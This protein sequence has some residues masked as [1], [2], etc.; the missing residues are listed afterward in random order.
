M[1]PNHILEKHDFDEYVEG[2]SERFY[3]EDDPPGLSPGRYFRLLL[4][5]ILQAW[6]PSVRWR[7]AYR[8]QDTA[9]RLRLPWGP[10]ALLSTRPPDGTA[11]T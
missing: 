5:G 9:S 1:P 10:A 2:L 7:G 4:I 8:A 11:T 6:M 3:A